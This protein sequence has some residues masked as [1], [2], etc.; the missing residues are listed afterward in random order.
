MPN[1]SSSGSPDQSTQGN[2]N[3]NPD[4][5]NNNQYDFSAHATDNSNVIASA[6]TAYAPQLSASQGS[7]VTY[8]GSDYG[9]IAAAT[10]IFGAA[11]QLVAAGAADSQT[12]A[13]IALAEGAQAVQD[14]GA[15]ALKLITTPFIWAAGIAALVI[16]GAVWFF[17]K[18]KK[19]EA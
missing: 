3:S 7:T 9:A 14:Q 1:A 11:Q 5:N 10:T 16:L 17:S 19:K 13:R 2:F 12:T 4:S 8:N 15:G 6:Q 18:R